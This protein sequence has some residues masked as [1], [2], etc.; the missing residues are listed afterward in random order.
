M[1]K[2]YLAAFL[3]A[4]FCVTAF[5]APYAEQTEVTGRAVA[6]DGNDY[7]LPTN[8]LPWNYKIKLTPYL[9]ESDGNKRFTFDGEVTIQI[10]STIN[11]KTLI[12]HTKNLNYTTRELWSEDAPDNKTSLG[13][14]TLNAVTDKIQYDLTTELVANKTYFLHFV[15]NGTMDD[16]MHG[17][18]R[19]S[20]VDS[21]NNTRWI[22]STQFQTN[23]A[24]RAFPS[25]DEPKFKA[26]FDVTIRRP[27]S[28]NSFGNTRI[29][30][31]ITNGNYV[32]DVYVQTPRMS[33]YILAFIVS[34]FAERSNTNFGVIARPEYYDQ[35]EY[36]Y[37]VGQQL[38]A[39]LNSY[40]GINYYEMG[41]DKMH[42]AAIPDFSAG[43]MENWGLLTYRERALLYD[44]ESTT[45]SAKQSIATVVAH[46]QT[47]M[48]FGDLVTC[49]WWSYTWLNEGFA[50]YFQYFGTAM[51]ETELGL[52]Q[53]FVV[54]QVQVVMS[55][56]STNNTNPMSDENTNTPSDLSRMFNSISY[57]KGGSII[58]MVKHAIGEENFRRSLNDYLN[59]N[60]YTNT[61]PANLL[62]IW[63][64]YWP[65]Q[66][67]SFAENVF[68]SFT[69][70][71]G[72]PLITVELSA[73]KK[74]FTVKQERFLLKDRD[75]ANTE[76]LYTVPISYTTSD[77]KDFINTTPKFY[78]EAS[79]TPVTFDLTNSIE[80]II[81][82]IQESGY[83]RVNYD[84]STWDAIHQALHSANWGSIHELNRAQIVDDLLNL[85]RAD[86]LKYD[87]ALEV[88]E[89]LESETNYLPW[90]SAFN[91]FSYIN[92]RLGSDTKQFSEYILELTKTVYDKLGF[93]ESTSNSALDIYTRAKV[94]SW[95]CK[96]GNEECISKSKEYF[97]KINTTPVPVNI[98]SVV[99][100]NALRYG[101][102]SDYDTLF[103]KFLTS[104]SAT[105]RTLIL[106]TLGCVKDETLIQKYFNAILSDDIRRQDK[107]SAL[108]SLY[109]ENNEN[110]GPVFKL[111]T[112]NYEKLADAMGSYSSVATVISNIATRFT[113]ESEKQS[114]KAFNDQNKDKFGS[115]QST[116]LSSEKTVDENLVW[117]TNKLG[118]FRTYLNNR[119]GAATNTIAILTML[120]CALVGR[121]LQ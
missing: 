27:A 23:H 5:A 53:Q 16:D 45:L 117:A 91:G 58:R 3:G 104:N 92:I 48:W 38:L 19:S 79:K 95:S 80:W 30:N 73:D 31:K 78:L 22:G 82:N 71:V 120:V 18:Y 50:R 100:C 69:Q 94:L 20:Y 107:S 85:A 99:Y 54:D 33:T 114:L 56:D 109:T 26:T 2:Q 51:V 4:F 110:V 93:V 64:Q 6:P 41:N 115:A 113:T 1:A 11:T 15:Y 119:N 34:E 12:M 116:L 112:D 43:A 106:N 75:T 24:R 65:E 84:D 96:F 121:F 67:R 52:D 89:Y 49:D 108:S 14:G 118:Q 98:R 55:M 61:I 88:L 57:N 90:T 103:N 105:E 42:M 7:R 63:Q 102:E 10:N 9:L 68:N 40:F 76:L 62:T 32:E 44:K 29:S 74:S 86:I 36:S 35:T 66:T 46:E 25:F 21:S 37:T 83:Y 81:L 39:A 8:I 47:H 13:A 77:A 60:K 70:Q 72:Y 17:F 59:Q 28:M 87:K 97:A 101:N 111:V